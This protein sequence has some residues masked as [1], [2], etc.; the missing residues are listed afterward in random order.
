MQIT[1]TPLPHRTV[2]D[3]D[4]ADR[5]DFLQGLLSNSVLPCRDGHAIWAA[6]LT[7]QGKFL[8]DMFVVPSGD[9]LLI[10][11]DKDGVD[12][13]IKRLTVYRLRSK[14]T[15][16][17]REDLAVVAGASAD[18]PDA[19]ADPRHPE[20][21]TRALIPVDD[22]QNVSPA[23]DAETFSA[24]D[25]HRIALGLPDGRR[26]LTPEKD[27][28]IEAN[29]DRLG[30]IDFKKGCYVGQEVTAR[31][32]YRGLAKKRLVPLRGAAPLATGTAL[33]ADGKTMG[34]IRSTSGA[35][36]LAMLKL[37]ALDA[38]VDADGATVTPSLPDWWPAP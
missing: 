27:T 30:G 28:L 25:Q 38:P 10:D 8:H 14:V 37:D 16:T 13:L 22:L 24:W 15:I 23:S 5:F 11:T 21:G 12:E 32:H 19:F 20:A 18:S 31:M 17:A 4:G 9:I 1:S 2:L 33:T 6:L 7:P 36:A 29:Y 3:I 34:D 26:D 35:M